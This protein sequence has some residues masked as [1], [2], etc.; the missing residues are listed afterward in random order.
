MVCFLQ[1]GI[2]IKKFNLYFK[3]FNEDITEYFLKKK[4]LLIIYIFFD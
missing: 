3:L 2:K 1:Y 4:M